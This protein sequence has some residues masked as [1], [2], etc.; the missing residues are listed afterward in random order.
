MWRIIQYNN[1]CGGSY[2]SG[3]G[4][5]LHLGPQILPTMLWEKYYYFCEIFPLDPT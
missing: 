4:G 2:A 1:Y 3:G 5:I